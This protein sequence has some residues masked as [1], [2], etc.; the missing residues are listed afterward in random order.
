MTAATIEDAALQ[1]PEE[2]RAQLAHKLLLSLDSQTEIEIADDWRNEASR[3]AGD[4]D[5]GVATLV[6]A[7][8]V[9]AAAQALLR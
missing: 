7:D 3:R 8:A 9:R 4:I 5:S 6:S 2:E 1:L